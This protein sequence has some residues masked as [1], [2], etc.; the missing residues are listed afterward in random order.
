MVCL[1]IKIVTS[2][3]GIIY[4]RK[5]ST[6]GKFKS[7]LS[8]RTISLLR[9][10]NTIK[11]LWLKY[12]RKI[13]WYRVVMRKMK[14]EICYVFWM[15]W[16]DREAFIYIPKKGINLETIYGPIRDWHNPLETRLRIIYLFFY[17]SN[18]LDNLE[19]AS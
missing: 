13:R 15:I 12:E 16:D 2:K 14:S 4:L 6:V 5:K 19:K 11:E 17:K 10:K 7:I 9:L 18:R 3:E 1:P 8:P